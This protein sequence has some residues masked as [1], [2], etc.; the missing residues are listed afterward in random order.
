M[1]HAVRTA[2]IGCCGLAGTLVALAWAMPAA[3]A[4]CGTPG[5]PCRVADG[6]YYAAAPALRAGDAPR[7]VILFLHG[8]GR[9]GE[10]VVADPE[11][12]APIVARGYVLLA[13]S[14]SPRDGRDGR[15]WSLGAKPP[16]RDEAA[17][18]HEVLADAVPRFGL[19]RDRVLVAGFSLGAGL[20]WQ[21]ACREPDAFAAYAPVAGAFWRGQPASCAGPVRILLTHGWRDDAVPLE[22]EDHGHG[23]ESAAFDGVELWRRV[24]G[25]ADP[26]AANYTDV[27]PFWQR[28]WTGCATGSALTFVLEPD[29]H[30]MPAGWA[31]MALDWFE[32][33]LPP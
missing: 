3:A 22:G 26:H 10:E 12:A 33:V 23:V 16:V 8:A 6:E 18:L 1:V 11:L 5:V 31:D 13:P 17:F 19:D 15:F 32:Q 7:G 21:L 27:G 4:D 20:V 28:S 14:G 29:G 2:C 25:C 30:E 9:S 24:N